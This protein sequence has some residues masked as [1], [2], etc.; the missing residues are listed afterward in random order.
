[1][2]LWSTA[3]AVALALAFGA[4]PAQADP[5]AYITST[6]ENP[7]RAGEILQYEVGAK[8]ALSPKNPAT[9]ATDIR[10]G[11]VV[12]SPDG[13]SAYVTGYRPLLPCTPPFCGGHTLPPGYVAQFDVGAGGT[14]SPKSPPTV[15]A[16]NFPHAE[17]VNPDGKSL[18]VAEDYN[19]GGTSFLQYDVGPGGTLSLKSPPTNMYFD[20]L[21]AIAVTPAPVPTRREQCKNGGWRNF[22]QFRNQGSCV[23][24]VET[25][26]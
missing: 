9:V 16:A 2:R 17:A 21:G 8:G 6:P 3:V 11:V 15:A 7:F 13:K 22:A 23:S 12:V 18:Y 24:F 20:Y 14:L 26:P 25:H 4:A 5:F 1:M 10:P 19:P